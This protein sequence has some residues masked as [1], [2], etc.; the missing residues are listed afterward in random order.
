VVT[1][2]SVAACGKSRS[3]SGDAGPGLD[4]ASA[5]A[6]DGL[7]R[8]G[9]TGGLAAPGTGGAAGAGGASGTGGRDGGAGGAAGATTSDGGAGETGG[10][11][12]V[13][14]LG[15]GGAGSGGIPG[16]GTGGAF[17]GSG[18][19]L[20]SGGMAGGGS[21]GAPGFGGMTGPCL[22][23]GPGMSSGGTTG[24]GTPPADGKS[25]TGSGALAC[26]GPAQKRALICSG[27]TWQ[28]RETCGAAQ[29]CDQ[30][31]GVCT[32]ILSVCVGHLSGVAF[33]ANDVVALCA[34]DLISA[35]T[36]LCCGACQDG[37]CQAAT[38]GD[39]KLAA[40]EECDDG[41]ATAADGCEPDCK[42]SK[43][44]AMAAGS[45][46]TCA[47]LREGL[48]RC[49]G[50]NDFGQL[51]LGTSADLSA[52]KPY[53]NGVVALGAPAAAIAA[54]RAH[55]CALMQDASVR[56]WGQNDFGQLGLGHTQPIGD[57]EPPS[58]QHA[59]VPLGAPVKAIAAG[60]NTT[61]AIL[62]TGALRCWG[63]ND[64][65][66]LGLGHTN[67]IGDDET[68]SA[69]VA[70]VTL[71]DTV[72]AVGPGGDHTCVV[73][74]DNDTRCWGRDDLDQLGIAGS[75]AQIGDDE[76]PTAVGALQW[77]GFPQFG[78]IA[79]GATRTFAWFSDG[80][81]VR[82][83]GDNDDGGLGLGYTGNDP[84]LSPTQWGGLSF[85]TPVLGVAVGGLHACVWLQ[86]NELRCFGVNA[87]AQLGQPD[88]QTLGDAI[89]FTYAPAVD[90]GSDAG[91]KPAYAK[92]VAAGALHTC[93]LLNTGVVRCWGYN[94]D[95]QL[96][97]G[98][99]S[100]A[101]GLAYVGGT[102]ASVPAL[103]DPVR[104]FGPTN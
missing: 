11:G 68:P 56:C 96:G 29:N 37:A 17:I 83:W 85:S 1:A 75:M 70:T 80:S 16:S 26:D 20:G 18:G 59:A 38:C 60:G 7:S 8:L 57:D 44:I 12:G 48:V 41:N 104:V 76:P 4:G 14:I 13:V 94:A 63:Q 24:G 89:P 3:T 39:G 95:G 62:Q 45:T 21:G 99:A 97:L 6:M 15:S 86:N 61:C 74:D 19:G 102:P 46:H 66:Q 84:T 33:C 5:D 100:G 31:S 67:D 25:C 71:D 65:G 103:L 23:S 50:A 72:R 22:A 28:V 35:S 92:I 81:A 69:A 53:Q 90:L 32:D 30:S 42:L 36:T 51:G 49:W 88:T 91:G 64:F 34:P 47:L 10:S 43:V 27:G 40:G 73:L 93:V 98:F 55:T 79:A 82:G 58:A 77:L 52:Q 2:L 78:T 87:D 54:G 101:P 9:G